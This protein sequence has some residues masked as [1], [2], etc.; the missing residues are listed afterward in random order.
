MLAVQKKGIISIVRRHG[1]TTQDFLVDETQNRNYCAL[2]VRFPR[3]KQEFKIVEFP[4][5]KNLFHASW[6]RSA[7]GHPW[8][9]RNLDDLSLLDTSE[10]YEEFD[11]WLAREV[12]PCRESG[13]VA[14]S[15]S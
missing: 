10:L 4:Q 13:T 5:N 15:A 7:P 3:G 8:A 14:P 12:K 1:L 2:T 11:R 9:A 6:R